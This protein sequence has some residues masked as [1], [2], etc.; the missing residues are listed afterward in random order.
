MNK[1]KPE[2]FFIGPSSGWNYHR[3][4]WSGAYENIRT[5]DRERGPFAL[6]ALPEFS[7]GIVEAKVFLHIACDSAGLLFR[8]SAKEN[9]IHGYEIVLEPREQRI[10]LRRHAGELSTLVQVS[11]D[12]PTARSLPVKLQATN[13]RIRVWLGGYSNLVIDFADPKP[14]LTAGHVG[15]RSWGAALSIDDLVLQPDGGAPVA[16]RDDRLATPERRAR[17]AFCLLLLNLN[18]V[19]YV[20]SL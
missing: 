18:E 5:V 17:E 20:D 2:H 3:G 6:A 12:V 8:A 1:L 16:I 7:N 11:A 15:A 4:R 10:A 14:I 9:E 19:V 13:D